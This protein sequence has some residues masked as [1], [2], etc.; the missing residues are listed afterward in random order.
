MAVR[1]NIRFHYTPIGQNTVIGAAHYNTKAS[2][3][4]VVVVVVVVDS[5]LLSCR[6]TR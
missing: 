3:V 6:V 5:V 2:F 1:Q 4:V